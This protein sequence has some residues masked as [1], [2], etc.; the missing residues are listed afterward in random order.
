MRADEAC[1]AG[2]QDISAIVSKRDAA[3][4]QG[5]YDGLCEDILTW[6]DD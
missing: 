3:E 5:S 1:G 4:D 2:D 6:I